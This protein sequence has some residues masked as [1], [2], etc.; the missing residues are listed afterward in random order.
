MTSSSASHTALDFTSFSNVINGK[1]VKS[2]NT[3]HSLNPATKKLLA[4]VPIATQH[5]LDDAVAA[6]RIGFGVWSN[7]ARPERKAALESFADGFAKYADDFASLMSQETGKVSRESVEEM[8]HGPLWVHEIN[9][10]VLP[11]EVT[12]EA[13]RTVI[14]RYTPLGVVGAIVPWNYPVMLAFAKLAPALLTGNTVILKPSPFAPYCVLKLAELAQRFFPP[15]VIQALSGDDSLGPW[16]A[17]HPGIDKIS[18]TGSVA[19]GKKV[20]ETASKTLKRVT[21]ELGGKDPAVICKDVDI[22][23]VADAVA[24][25]ALTNAGQVCCAVKRV[26]VHESIYPEF[27]TAFVDA[28]KR[29]EVGDGLKKDAFYGPLQNKMQ[30]DRVRSFLEDIKKDGQNVILGE[31]VQDSSGYFMNPT[32]VDN[33]P[34]DS[35]IVVEEPFGKSAIKEAPSITSCSSSLFRSTD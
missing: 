12:E 20:M 16:L 29:L 25:Q 7:L 24:R 21:L 13:D 1:L 4:E 10:I 19:T 26:Y 3:L 28:A 14:V 33:P 32:V 2:K 23:V 6:A 18:F 22:P 8:E 34:D 35:R 30:Y 15:G 17:A 31:S 9:K 5:D 11:D 27:R